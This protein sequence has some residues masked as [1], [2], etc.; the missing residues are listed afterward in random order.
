MRRQ[1]SIIFAGS[2]Q[3]SADLVFGE[4]LIDR[5]TDCTDGM[6]TIYSPVVESF[7]FLLASFFLHH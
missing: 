6:P 1:N 2:H 5:K 7:W 4:V 3:S